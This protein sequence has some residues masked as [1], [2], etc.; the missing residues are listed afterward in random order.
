VEAGSVKTDPRTGE[1][2]MNRYGAPR[3]GS[4]KTKV[5]VRPDAGG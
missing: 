4:D 5:D 3:L 1:L 2:R